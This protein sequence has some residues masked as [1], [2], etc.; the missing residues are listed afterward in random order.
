MPLLQTLINIGV[1]DDGKYLTFMVVRK[2]GMCALV[3]VKIE[4][5]TAWMPHENMVEPF[6]CEFAECDPDG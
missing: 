2:D 5:M 1:S 4:K 3:S 6:M